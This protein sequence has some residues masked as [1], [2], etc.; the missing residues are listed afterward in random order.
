MIIIKYGVEGGAWYTRVSKASYGVGL[1]KDIRMEASLLLAH[2]V[3]AIGDDK[4]VLFWEACWC[5]L[6]S[7]YSTFPSLYSMTPFKGGWVVDFWSQYG[8]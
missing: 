6:A 1:W 7:L 8:C 3:F 5:G 4:M 2:N